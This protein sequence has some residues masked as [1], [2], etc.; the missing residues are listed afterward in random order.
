MRILGWGLWGAGEEVD[1]NLAG[2]LPRVLSYLLR[3]KR[4]SVVK[5]F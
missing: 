1:V 3:I 5:P 4:T 2:V